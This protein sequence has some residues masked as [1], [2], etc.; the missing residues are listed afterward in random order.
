MNEKALE[1]GL[2]NTSFADPSGLNP[3]NVSSAYDLSRLI[4]FAASD[5]RIA[6]I[7]QTA[8]YTGQTNRRDDQHPQHQ[9]TGHGRHGCGRRKD[10]L[11]R[12]GRAIASRRCCGCR[13]ATIRSRSSSSA[14]SPI[15]A[16]SGR[17]ATSSIGCPKRRPMLFGKEEL[18]D[19]SA[20]DRSTYSPSVSLPRRAAASPRH[21]PPA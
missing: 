12:Q 4:S 15:P 20:R 5:E 3:A 9:P 10:R 11:H 1:L 17:R 8:T 21:L 16:D 2:E 14:R 13:R 19:Q 18:Q 6:P 7:M